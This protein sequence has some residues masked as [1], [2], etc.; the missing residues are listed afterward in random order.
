MF[1]GVWGWLTPEAFGWLVRGALLCRD[2]ECRDA[3][4]MFALDFDV[5]SNMMIVHG[6]GEDCSRS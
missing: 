3:I 6:E 4:A 5:V 1:R 2:H